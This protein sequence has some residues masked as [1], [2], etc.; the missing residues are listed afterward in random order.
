[1]TDK[2]LK[3]LSRPQLIEIIYQLQLK[4]EELI[5]ENEKLSEEL[6]DRRIHID[7]AGNLADAVLVL[8]NVMQTAQE[9][10]AHYLEEMQIRADSERQQIL[11]DAEAE[12][13]AVLE[14]AKREAEAI[15]ASA[16][17]KNK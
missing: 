17:K 4:Q 7:E 5:A 15:T 16:E 13:A 12:A 14:R 10:A 6:K 11:S 8:H 9:A 2:E 3:R 1:M